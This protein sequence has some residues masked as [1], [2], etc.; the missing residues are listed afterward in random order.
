[1]ASTGMKLNKEKED[2]SS[3]NFVEP[4]NAKKVQVDVTE[5]LPEHNEKLFSTK[6]RI[7]NARDLVTEILLVED[8]PSLNPW[9]FRMWFLGI[10]MS[11]FAG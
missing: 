2:D 9:T 7:R 8:D 11:V 3:I 10:G 6:K 4:T 5:S 1:M